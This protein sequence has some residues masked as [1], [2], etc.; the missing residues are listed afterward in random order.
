[1]HSHPNVLR[2]FGLCK[3]HQPVEGWA[4]VTEYMSNGSLKDFLVEQ[5]EALGV[6][7]LFGFARSAA[8]GMLHLSNQTPPIL[9]RTIFLFLSMYV[10]QLLHI[11]L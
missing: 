7:Q 3:L 10:C 4:F 5:G 11:P 6:R 1:M 8:A 9:H 2:F